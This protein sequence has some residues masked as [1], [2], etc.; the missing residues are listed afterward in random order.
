M[1]SQ[2]TLGAI[3]NRQEPRAADV[4]RPP[5]TRL[6]QQLTSFLWPGLLFAVIG[7][8]CVCERTLSKEQGDD[9]CI[10]DTAQLLCQFQITG[11]G[12]FF[13]LLFVCLFVCCVCGE[14]I[15][16]SKKPVKSSFFEVVCNQ[17]AHQLKSAGG[18]PLD[19]CLFFIRSS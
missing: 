1:G 19:Q 18:P 11:R 9:L 8:V 3:N 5:Q 14:K 6:S 7:S 2:L 16:H 17:F 13:F 10:T 4:T 15:T 12:L